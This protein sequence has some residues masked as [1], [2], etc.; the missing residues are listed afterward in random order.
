MPDQFA[1]RLTRR[2]RLLLQALREHARLGFGPAGLISMIDRKLSASGH[3]EDDAED[4]ATIG[5]TLDCRLNEELVVLKLLL[6]EALIREPGEIAVTTPCGMALLGLPVGAQTASG[7]PPVT[8][9]IE[10]I[11]GPD[12]APPEMMTSLAGSQ[13]HSLHLMQ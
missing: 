4:H 1:S 10:G 13:P 5:S 8:I 11:T 2:D 12:R 6:R 9:T 3:L 7:T